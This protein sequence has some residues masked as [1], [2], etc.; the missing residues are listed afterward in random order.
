MWEHCVAI[1]DGALFSYLLFFSTP[2]VR[3]DLAVVL[4]FLSLVTFLLI[5]TRVLGWQVWTIMADL[6]FHFVIAAVLG[7]S[8][9]GLAQSHQDTPKDSSYRRLDMLFCMLG[10]GQRDHHLYDSDAQAQGGCEE[11]HGDSRK[12]LW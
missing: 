2:S 10:Q 6:H 12:N 7:E 3:W 5:Y 8:S 4:A 11:I 9:L 1:G